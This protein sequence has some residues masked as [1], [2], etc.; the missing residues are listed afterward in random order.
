MPGIFFFLGILHMNYFSSL[1]E[2]DTQVEKYPFDVYKYKKAIL[3]L[4]L[5]KQMISS[6]RC[7]SRLLHEPLNNL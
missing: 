7:L 5:K 4:M 2:E 3:T 6:L 1:L